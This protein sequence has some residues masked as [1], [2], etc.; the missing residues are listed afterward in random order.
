MANKSKA[1]NGAK[2]FETIVEA[3]NKAAETVVKASRDAATK[4]YEHFYTL[5]KDNVEA[6][7]KAGTDAFKGYEN[8]ADLGK[9]NAE[10]VA[11][12]G[13]I[14]AKGIEAIGS[15]WAAF[16]KTS[17][18]ESVAASKALMG[19]KSV[20]EFVD[21]QGTLVR[22]SLD[23]VVAESAALTEMSAKVTSEAL[24]PITSRVN[25]TIETLTKH[26]AH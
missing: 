23:K 5:G 15:R 25:A 9:D 22:S 19:C 14:F 13:A 24:A 21:V 10:A 11:Q 12:S 17:F 16:A 1:E 3:G 4:G 2:G 6:A 7:V 18:D 8:V 20:K 26:A